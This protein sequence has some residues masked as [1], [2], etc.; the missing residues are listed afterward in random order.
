M[1]IALFIISFIAFLLGGFLVFQLQDDDTK[2][3]IQWENK[4]I[5]DPDDDEEPHVTK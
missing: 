3:K 1:K 5:I 4:L 2:Y